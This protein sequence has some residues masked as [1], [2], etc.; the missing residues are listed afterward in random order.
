MIIIALLFFSIFYVEWRYLKQKNRNA[1]TIFI[2]MS[3]NAFLFLC[4]EALFF[5]RDTFSMSAFI[6]SFFYPFDKLPE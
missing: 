4:F 1:R 2:V 6:E 5:F 3:T